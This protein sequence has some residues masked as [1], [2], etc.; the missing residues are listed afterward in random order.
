LLDWRAL[1]SHLVLIERFANTGTAGCGVPTAK[2]IEQIRHPSK[3]TRGRSSSAPGAR[4]RRL[5][6]HLGH[7]RAVLAVCRQVLEIPYHTLKE[8][9]TYR[10][11]GTDYFERYRA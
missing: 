11:L 8:P 4:Y 9:A 10:E 6:V 2:S 7:G 5:R 1:R 3:K